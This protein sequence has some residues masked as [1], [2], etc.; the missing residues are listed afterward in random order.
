MHEGR[1]EAVWCVGSWLWSAGWYRGRSLRLSE[2]LGVVA[3]VSGGVVGVVIR[4][5]VGTGGY[6]GLSVRLTE[7][8]GVIGRVNGAVVRCVSRTEGEI[9]N[10]PV[11][12]VKKRRVAEGGR[13]R[14]VCIPLW[15]RTRSRAASVVCSTQ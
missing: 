11:I 7:C 10:G 4:T 12:G 3:L 8:L 5:E 9:E 14:V 13:R 6:E 2:G 1:G 15:K